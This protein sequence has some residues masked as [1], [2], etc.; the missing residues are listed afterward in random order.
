MQH[1]Q[2]MLL[3]QQQQAAQKQQFARDSA[4]GANQQ[5]PGSPKGE[6]APSPS[7]RPRLDGAPFTNG[8]Q[9]PVMMPNGRGMPQGMP[10]QQQVSAQ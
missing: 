5:R 8:Q 3:A 4:D 10:D 6:N 2:Q 7:K 9:Q 1:Q